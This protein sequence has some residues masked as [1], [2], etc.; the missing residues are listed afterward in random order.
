MKT[1]KTVY[2]KE[3]FILIG[4]ALLPI[5]W[6]VLEI[7]LLTPFNNALKILS[8]IALISIIFKC[9][10]ETIFNPLYK[11]LSKN[12]YANN[13][14]K[15]LIAKK[16]LIIY[17]LL[18]TLFTLLIFTV[19]QQIMVISKIPENIFFETQPFLKLYVIACGLGVISKYLY[20]FNVISKNTKQMFFYLLIRVILTATLF[21]IL[22]PKFS[23]NLGVNAVAITDIIVNTLTI[24]Y[25]LITFPK[26]E[27]TQISINKKEYFKLTLFSFLETTIRNVVYYFVILVFLNMIDNQDK[28]FIANEFIWGIMLIPALAQSTLIKQDIAN[29]KNYNLNKYFLN[30]ILLSVFMFILIPIAYLTFKHIY[31][32]PNHLEYFYVLLKLLPC[33]IIFIFDSV[34]ESYFISTGKLHHVL[35]QS[36]ITN[37]VVYL[38]AYILYLTNVWVVTLNSIIL[39]FNLGIVFSS[40][41][42]ITTYII[43]RKKDAN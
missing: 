42:T 6:K 25:L 5:V 39:L 32:L 17:V 27:K 3:Y 37:I 14:S 1:L 33:Y 41:Y 22:A 35:I 29:N 40:L 13:N 28:Y 26:C 15:N 43:L 2:C 31:N 36:V 9:F 19:I 38:T 21:L 16:F 30:S 11:C 24:V 34:I 8:Q 23:L 10:E 20:T 18:T 12:N 7:A 4:L